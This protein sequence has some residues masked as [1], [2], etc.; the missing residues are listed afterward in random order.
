MKILVVDDDRRIVKTTCDILKIKGHEAIAAYTGEEGV[1]MVKTEAPDCVLMDIRMPGISGVEALRQMK[2]I[3]P[4][5]PVVLVSAYT[6]GEVAD[7]AKHAGAYAVLSKPLNFQMVL[8][9]LSL[10]HKEENILVVDD[11]PG[12][13]KT[14]KDILILRGYQVETET[15][16]EKVLD[17]LTNNYKLVIVLDLK[18]GDVNG[19]EVLKRIQ[20]KYPNKPVVMMTGYRQEMGASIEKASQIGAYTVLYKPFETDA[21]LQLIEEI[22]I[23]KLQNS[24][25]ST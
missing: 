1:E 20:A 13:G 2:A 14:L 5:L 21:L 23:K 10:L 19:V 17:H 3:S 12:F 11:D 16:P 4:A 9:F 24:L 8:S 15:E 6:T 7:E 25:V 22:R 18:L